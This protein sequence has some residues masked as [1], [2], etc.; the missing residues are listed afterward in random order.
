MENPLDNPNDYKTS[1]DI[2]CGWL[3]DTAKGTLQTSL[4]IEC[5]HEMF[6]EVGREIQ[7]LNKTISEAHAFAKELSAGNL[8]YELPP[9]TNRIASP[10]KALH[11]MLSHLTW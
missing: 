3:R 8:N 5:L 9:R 2:I 7:F 10:L 11:A 1:V 4:E 6:R